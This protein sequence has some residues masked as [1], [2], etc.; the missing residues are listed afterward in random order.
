M[1]PYEFSAER[2]SRWMAYVLRHNPTRYGLEADRHG[3]VDLEEFVRIA[4][5]RYPQVAAEQLRTLIREGGAGRFEVSG[6]QLRARYGHSIPIEPA[7]EPVEPPARLYHGADAS[8][9]PSI[10]TG[11]LAPVDRR[12]LHLSETIEDAL[13][14][15]QRRTDRPILFRVQAREA[16]AAGVAF[17]KEGRVFLAAQIPPAFLGIEPIPEPQSPSV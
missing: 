2:F 4:T 10:L 1:L 3:Y 13:A 11:G 8:R 16:Q 5:R 17:Y 12:M 15:I 6:A 7:G 9:A 14:V